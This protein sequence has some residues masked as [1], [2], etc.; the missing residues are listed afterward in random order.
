M[1]APKAAELWCVRVPG[2][3]RL[4]AA[5]SHSAAREIA[6]MHN[7]AVARWLE[8]NYSTG[9]PPPATAEPWPGTVEVHAQLIAE[10]MEATR[11]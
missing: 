9:V 5:V 10:Q 8:Q 7:D 2:A 11:G 1:T 3:P 6:A 4:L